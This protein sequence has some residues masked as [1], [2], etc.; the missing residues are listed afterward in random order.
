MHHAIPQK[1]HELQGSKLVFLCE[2]R[3]VQVQIFVDA[4][5]QLLGTDYLRLEQQ[6]VHLETQK[7]KYS[8]SHSLSER[9]HVSLLFCKRR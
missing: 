6:V 2:R 5:N 1:S 8:N 9:D 4:L 3:R 7:G